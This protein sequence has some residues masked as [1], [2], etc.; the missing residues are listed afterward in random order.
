[1]NKKLSSFF[2]DPKTAIKNVALLL[3]MV[4]LVVY[5]CF[6]IIP[7]FTDKIETENAYLVSVYDATETEA[8]IIRDEHVISKDSGG[9]LVTLVKDGERVSKGQAFA[10]VYNTED[11]VDLQEQIN[12][13]DRKIEI[14]E[15]SAI[16]T[17]MYVTDISKTDSDINGYMNMLYEGVADGDLSEMVNVEKEL[18][19]GLNK[20][21]IIIN[22]TESY[23]NE[24]ASLEAER[25]AIESR[26][27]A[28]SHRL[29]ATQSGYFYGDVD[30]YENIFVPEMLSGLTMDAF[31]QT[32]S[33]SPDSSVIDGSYGKIV[34]D[35]VWNVVAKADKE[36]AA[37]YVTGRS[38]TV[39]FPS[40]SDEE[41]TMK[42]I[43][44]IKTTSDEKALLVFRANT[45]PE[46]F[47]FLR[48]QQMNVINDKH[49]GLAVPKS[50]LRIVGGEKGVY[51]LD[52]DIVRFRMVDII[53]ENDDYYLVLDPSTLDEDEKKEWLSSHEEDVYPYISLY[54]NVI[55]SGKALF[56]GKTIA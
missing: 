4:F 38:Y 47:T 35:F 12:R 22:M 5:A 30:G 36:S 49:T 44:I 26:I 2:V 50:A 11:T 37:K 41:M 16:D 31:K 21:N 20:K 54:D 40:F 10:N 13:I 19:V 14:L 46:D 34:T 3:L 51:I 8:Y 23:T 28:V 43:D 55:V 27:N 9:V 42:L 29:Y 56:D 1:M 6:Q 15:K 17:D 18:L 48:K 52:G 7:T 32:E 45:A 24:I 53:Y 39:T 25:R 33:K